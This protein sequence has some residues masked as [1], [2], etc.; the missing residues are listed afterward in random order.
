[1]WKMA[2]TPNHLR[3]KPVLLGEH[4]REVYCDLLGYDEAQYDA[5]IE[6]GYVGTQVPS[7]IW[8]PPEEP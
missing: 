6:K 8:Q 4:N 1:M 3:S 5:L 2:H 7:S